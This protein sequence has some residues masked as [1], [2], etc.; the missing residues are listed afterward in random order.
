MTDSLPSK[1]VSYLEWRPHQDAP[2]NQPW[3]LV[4]VTPDREWTVLHAPGRL[5]LRGASPEPPAS[6]RFP[7]KLPREKFDWTITPAFLNSV[8]DAVDAVSG[9]YDLSM[10][11]IE[12]VLLALEKVQ[13]SPP[14]APEWQPIETA[15][16]DGTMILTVVMGYQPGIYKWFQFE[17][18]GGRWTPDPECFLE[19]AHFREWID[20]NSYDPTHWMP[21]PSGPT[22]SGDA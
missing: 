8:K 13:P 14:P 2:N 4:L 7:R 9:H 1:D 19:E 18:G 16:K 3:S 6:P 11:E 21:I 5:E 20:G 10:E 17:D 12:E 15:P 22:K